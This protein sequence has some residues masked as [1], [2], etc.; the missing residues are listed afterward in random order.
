MPQFHLL[1]PGDGASGAHWS[2]EQLMAF[3]LGES[4]EAERIKAAMKA[5]EQ[6]SAR[7]R[8]LARTAQH[9]RDLAVLDRSFDV[10][11]QQRARLV[12]ILPAREA[13][14]LT[15]MCERAA[16]VAVLVRDSLAGPALAGYRSADVGDAR[17]LRYEC[18]GG[19]IDLRV[20]S[21][22]VAKTLLVTGQVTTEREVRTLRALRHANGD[23]VASVAVSEDGYVEFSIEPDVYAIEL[24]AVDG[25]SS[26]VPR[27]DLRTEATTTP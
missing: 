21:Q 4:T 10:S 14:W 6:L 8:H 3:V 16:E 17:M 15:V 11:P 9:V 19:T 12:A 20:E 26:V 1:H 23:E 18:F 24:I 2:H 7:V 5:D 13:N 25:T 27:V 22:P